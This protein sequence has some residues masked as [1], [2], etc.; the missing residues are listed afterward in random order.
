MN[1]PIIQALSKVATG[2]SLITPE[3]IPI[4]L[5]ILLSL[6]S[7]NLTRE[8]QYWSSALKRLSGTDNFYLA[9]CTYRVGYFRRRKKD[10]RDKQAESILR[11]SWRIAFN[12]PPSLHVDCLICSMLDLLICS[13]FYREEFDKGR[14]S[15]MELLKRP[16]NGPRKGLF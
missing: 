14:E 1:T 13:L 9:Y 8:E 7:T 15:T 12:L 6:N 11:H 16:S 2:V 4:T 10:V 5:L 3:L